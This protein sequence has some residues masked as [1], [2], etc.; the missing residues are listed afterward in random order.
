MR[1][2]D[3]LGVAL[4]IALALLYAVDALRHGW[5]FL[6]HLPLL[7]VFAARALNDA[8]HGL[9]LDAYEREGTREYYM[10]Y[11]GLSVTAADARIADARRFA[12]DLLAAIAVVVESLFAF[13]ALGRFGGPYPSVIMWVSFGVGAVMLGVMIFGIVYAVRRVRS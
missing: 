6:W 10:R 3:A 5:A 12:R 11:A 13:D 7:G 2:A 1:R 9:P 4:A 8:I